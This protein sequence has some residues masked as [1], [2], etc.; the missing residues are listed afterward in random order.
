M[1]LQLKEKAVTKHDPIQHQE[2]FYNIPY[3]WT[4]AKNQKLLYDLRTSLVLSLLGDISDQSLLDFGCGD[5]RFTHELVLANGEEVYGV[6]IS[7]RALRFAQCL[8]PA[9]HFIRIENALPFDNQQLDAIMALD[10]LEHIPD[11]NLDLWMKEF[12][13]IL[14]PKGKLIVSVPTTRIPVSKAHFRHYSLEML[15]ESFERYSFQ[16]CI[17][18]FYFYKPFWLPN[19]LYKL[20]DFDGLWHLYRGLVKECD[21]NKG[22]YLI[23]VGHKPFSHETSL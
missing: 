21:Q 9:A 11:H 19:L 16:E 15:K 22:V 3:H 17:F 10:V 12:V 20:Y 7:E 6:D 1:L 23:G 14:K 2:G 5:G 4:Y 18:R 13:R 8:V